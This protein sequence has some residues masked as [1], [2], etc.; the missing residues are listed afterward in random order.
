[1][2]FD[3]A[4]PSVMLCALIAVIVAC[5]VLDLPALSTTLRFLRLKRRLA[6]ARKRTSDAGRQSR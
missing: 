4:E 1:M 3:L 5:T 2:S 6:Y